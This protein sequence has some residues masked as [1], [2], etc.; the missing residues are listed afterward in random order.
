MEI[1]CPNCKVE[2]KI[3]YGSSNKEIV[4]SNCKKPFIA[5]ANIPSTP[6]TET[7]P[8]KK[9]TLVDAN[10]IG[11]LYLWLGKIIL[12]LGGL[13][14]LAVQSFWAALSAVLTGFLFIAL[15]TILDHLLYIRSELTKFNDRNKK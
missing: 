10:D 12:I 13:I 11:F 9:T 15:G 4:C 3:P 5:K 6:T 7:I 14:G 1:N 8:L 2:N